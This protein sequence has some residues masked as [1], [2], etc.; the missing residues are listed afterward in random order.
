[1]NTLP[2]SQYQGIIAR[3]VTTHNFIY[4]YEPKS[5][6]Y[7]LFTPNKIMDYHGET[8]KELGIKKGVSVTFN[9]KDEIVTRVM[10][11]ET[12]KKSWW[13]RIF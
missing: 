1:M 7:Y 6:N 3:I 10:I 9:L 2:D 4:I 12:P 8:F 13:S 11:N 5:G